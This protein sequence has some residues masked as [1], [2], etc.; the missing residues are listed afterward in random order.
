MSINKTTYRKVSQSQ[1]EE[2]MA[3]SGSGRV[4]SLSYS[5]DENDDAHAANGNDEL[6]MSSSTGLQPSS[7]RSSNNA[8]S[9]TT[10]TTIRRTRTERI[11]DKLAARE[12]SI[13][14]LMCTLNLNSQPCIEKQF[15]F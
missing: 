15:L 1:G 7:G 11:S 9:T 13:I 5:D 4:G 8:T 10:G 12:L 14:I 3:A 2:P 6:S